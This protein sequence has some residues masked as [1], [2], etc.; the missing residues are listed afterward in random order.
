MFAAKAGARK[1]FAV[2]CSNIA[3]QARAIV[4]SN[5][6]NGIV[7]VIQGKMEEV[8][9][10]VESVDVIISEWMGYFLLYESMLDSVLFARDRYLKKD[11][12]IMMPDKAVLYMAGIEDS[13]Y[14]AEKLDYW[15]NVYGFD[16]SVIKHLAMSEPLVDTVSSEAVMT[17]A[18]PILSIDILTC[19]KEDLAFRTEFQIKANRNDY[20]HVSR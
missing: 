18:V 10:P 8:I 1:V 11:T 9:L 4:K 3:I 14:R 20:C 2:E 6:L 12:G 17:N 16:M 5:R 15:E 19:K 7:E 13:D